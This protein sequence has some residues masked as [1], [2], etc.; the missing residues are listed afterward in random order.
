M[1]K[2]PLF[3]LQLGIRII[4]SLLFDWSSLGSFP[5]W[6]IMVLVPEGFQRGY[7]CSLSALGLGRGLWPLLGNR[8]SVG[9]TICPYPNL[10]TA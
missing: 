4:S 2:V 3:Q 1:S 7:C 9:C 6:T 8:A 10:F 5:T